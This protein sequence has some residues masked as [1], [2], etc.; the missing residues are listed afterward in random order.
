MRKLESAESRQQAP[1]S[2]PAQGRAPSRRL[3]GL[4]EAYGLLVV[5]AVTLLFFSLWGGTSAAFPTMANADSIIGGQSALMVVS[6][7]MVLPLLAGEIDLSVGATAGASAVVTA[8]AMSR[9]NLPLV[10]AIILGLVFALL[11]GVAVGMLV[12]LVN[13]N[14]FVITFG[15]ATV[16]GGL[17]TWYTNSLPITSNISVGLQ[18]FGT[19]NW[20][21]LPRTLV[22][23]VPI[24]V[25]AILVQDRTPFGRYLQAIGSNKRA[26]QLVGIRVARVTF[27]SFIASS[28]MAGIGGVLLLA[29]AGGATPDAGSTLL[30]PAFTAVFLGMAT[31]RPGQPNVLGTVAAVLFL[32]A[33]VS[34]F[35]MAGIA[36]WVSDVFDGLALLAAI[37]IATW[38][39]RKQGAKRI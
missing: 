21:G 3:L 12:A 4:G 28:L 10:V 38:F 8:T 17:V 34:G 16:L 24:I 15:V 20:L 36:S 23:T 25:I 39:A 11:I 7:G 1:E 35:T 2:K 13:A 19:L 30:F 6:V 37:S 5:F 18:N 22:V 29:A 31:I 27:S 14:S 33:A 26:A 9:F 32:A